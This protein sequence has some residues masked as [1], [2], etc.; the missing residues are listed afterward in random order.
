MFHAKNSFVIP[1]DALT[2]V[3][4]HLFLDLS[5]VDISGL[6]LTPVYQNAAG[7]FQAAISPKEIF[8][9]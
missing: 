5:Q 8:S 4:P 2:P 1:V 3:L 9:H 7:D 6:I